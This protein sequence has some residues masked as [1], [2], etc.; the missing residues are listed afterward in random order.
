[1]AYQVLARKW[2]PG[3]FAEMAGQEHVLKA[4]TNALNQDRL[5][6]AYLFTGTRGV[7]KTTVARIFAKCL[8][9]EQGV[10]AIPCG[11]CGVCREIAE[12]RFVDLIEIDAASRTK[13][14]DMREL[15]DNVQYAP[16]RSRYKIYLIDEVHMLSNSSFNALL[17]TLE[18]PPPHV[19]F[20]LA[21]TD[22]QKL[23]VTILSRCLQFNLKNLSPQ[24][25][26]SHLTHV[27]QAENVPAEEA[28]LW[29]LARAAEGS[30]RDAMSLTD[31]AIAFGDGKLEA[32][33]VIE[34]LGT[35]E[36]HVVI[37]LLRTIAAQD[38]AAMLAQVNHMAQFAPDYAYV[39]QALAELLHRVAV[40]QAVPGGVDNS[41]GD[42]QQVSELAQTLTAE[43]TQL[44]YQIA[45]MGRKDLALA[46]DPRTGFEMALLRM[47]A[48]RP[49][50]KSARQ[51]QAPSAASSAASADDDK[52]SAQPGPSQTETA[53]A[54]QPAP[55]VEATPEPRQEIAAPQPEPPQQVAEKRDTPS[56]QEP[57]RQGLS[58]QG[59]QKQE[60]SNQGEAPVI[61][62]APVTPAQP[63][64]RPPPGHSEAEPPPVDDYDAY[65]ADDPG[66]S[67]ADY[68]FS[69]YPAETGY[70]D[71]GSHA[72]P[73][74]NP[75]PKEERPQ[76]AAPA[77]E[78]QGREAIAPPPKSVTE[79]VP[80]LHPGPGE[81]GSVNTT[82]P[83]VAA[84]SVK[85]SPAGPLTPPLEGEPTMQGMVWKDAVKRLAISGMTAT[86]A[87]RC[88]LEAVTPGLVIFTIDREHLDF[89]N[90]AQRERLRAAVSEFM[91][92]AVKIEVSAGESK[93]L[94]P[95]Q[96]AERRRAELQQQAETAIRNDPNIQM[97]A[98]RFGAAVI[99]NSIEPII[100]E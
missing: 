50:I 18:E 22:P 34:M 35:I 86:L 74:A 12:G 56:P 33:D 62:A 81:A 46:P 2:R 54:A 97:M 84:N 36:K 82:P 98:G 32:K 29:E 1:M 96:Y 55:A 68:G 19:K 53:V 85:K 47:I 80:G 27:L 11:E 94:T 25:I 28:A 77:R 3:N 59:P 51:I 100:Q 37:D 89:F 83:V 42:Q 16:T 21:T 20:L 57:P 41:F 95:L 45:L 66:P 65:F 61:D 69:G 30:M 88:A 14:E 9:C 63:I 87:Q 76:A 99:E 4:L 24:R 31:Q 39:L 93:W 91:G 38:C 10:S 7:G 6:H 71:D 67:D 44:Y 52:E 17:K 78:P 5:H 79:S 23:P 8:N 15:L 48:F 90:E 13:V 75:Q 49:N 60:P 70:P 92:E 43:D 64:E 58:Q 73:V 72:A 26:V 40:E